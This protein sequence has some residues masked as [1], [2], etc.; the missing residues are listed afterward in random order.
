MRT[1]EVCTGSIESVFAAAEGGANR[2]E[3]CANLDKGGTTPP[4][5]WV[6]HALNSTDLQVFTLIRPRSGD[7]LYTRNEFLTMKRDV[8]LFGKVGCQ[9]V[10]FGIL[11]KEGKIDIE[12]NIELISIARK[13]DMSATFHRAIDRTENIFDAMEDIIKLGFDRILTSGGKRTVSEGKEI[14]KEMIEKSGGKIIIMPGG[15]INENNIGELSHDL[16]TN[17][18]HGSFGKTVK[19]KMT[20]KK[21]GIDDYDKDF[22]TTVSC[23]DKIKK[24]ITILRNQ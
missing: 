16:K 24:A 6:E 11:T 5:S 4:L 21:E 18:F 8:Q 22:T 2:I 10:V 1:I 17:E 19:S 15:G 7:F 14:I 23:P 13:Y 3:L 12:R 20:F 9:G